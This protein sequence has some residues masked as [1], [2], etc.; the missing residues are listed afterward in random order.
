MQVYYGTSTAASLKN[1]GLDW[2][3]FNILSRLRGAE[4]IEPDSDLALFENVNIESELGG[5]PLKIPL[6]NGAF[7]ST[8]VASEN[9]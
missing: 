1:Y 2:S 3:H 5:I 4:G 7:G 9:W 6:A 8:M